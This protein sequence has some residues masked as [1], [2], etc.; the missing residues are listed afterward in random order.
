M[1]WEPKV[2]SRSCTAKLFLQGI[3]KFVRLLDF[4][5]RKKNFL[6]E[7][8]LKPPLITTFHLFIPRSH[9]PF[10]P[11]RAVKWYSGPT[12][13]MDNRM[14]CLSNQASSIRC[15][16]CTEYCSGEQNRMGSAWRTSTHHAVLPHST[17]GANHILPHFYRLPR[18][19]SAE[20]Y[21]HLI[22]HATDFR[23]D[24]TPHSKYSFSHRKPRATDGAQRLRSLLQTPA[25]HIQ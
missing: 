18:Y 17:A 16:V 13:M 6:N 15:S 9:R 11:F 20:F 5:R 10:L 22:I 7:Y 12:Y 8:P 21:H 14:I 2:F 19:R 1:Q 3:N 23:Y 24:T 25:L 4:W